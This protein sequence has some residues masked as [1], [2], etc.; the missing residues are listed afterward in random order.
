MRQVKISPQGIRGRVEDGLELDQVIDLVCAYACWIDKGPVLVVRD[1]RPSSKML[2]CAVNA[3]LSAS[4]R[5]VL[6]AGICP[7]PVG[8]FEAARRGTPGLISITGAHND[9]SWNGLKLFGARGQVLTSA[10][11]REILDLW[12]QDE[13]HRAS[14]L[15]LGE[16]RVLPEVIQSYI[17]QVTRWVDRDAIAAA[18][19]RVVVDACNGAASVVI[20]ELCLT[21]GVEL[22]PISCE[23]TGEFPHPPDPTRRN[24]AAIS[25]IIGP[26]SGAVGFGLS[27]DGERVA[28]VTELGH[29]VGREGTFAL[30]AEHLLGDPLAARKIVA[31]ATL[32]SRVNHLADKFGAEIIRCGVGVQEVMS[33]LQLEGASLGGDNS[34]GVVVRKT[35]L[36][37]DGLANLALLLEAMVQ[38]GG[39]QALYEALPLA[40]VRLFTVPCPINRAFSAMAQVRRQA[41]GRV[42]DLDGVRV[43]LDDG[44][45]HARVSNTEPVI[46]IACEAGSAEAVAELGAMVRNQVQAVSGKY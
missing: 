5:E 7:T 44:W 4:G 18:K 8:Q 25:S 22:I 1:T 14:H 35:H 12:H 26:V 21:L 40:H 10:E 20:R 39:A 9:V 30:L 13:Y 45:Y 11:G 32:D 33:T 17:Q 28:L 27:S 46:R 24:L 41:K 36:A 3:A 38:R 34:G 16:M 6:D 31:G 42:R 19:L 43:D 29:P 23:P 15:E 37:Y 2:L